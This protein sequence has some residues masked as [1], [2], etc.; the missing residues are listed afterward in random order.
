MAET[1]RLAFYFDLASPEC[2]L[3]AERV[4]HTLPG[5]IDWRPVRIA[6]EPGSADARSRALLERGAS[7]LGLLPLRWPADYPFDSEAAMIVATYA[8]SIGRGVAYAQAAFRQAFAGGHSLA[9]TDYVLLAGAAC[10]MHPNAMKRALTQRV[11]RE[12]LAR[13]TEDARRAGV[14]QLPA[15][16]AD[17]A[18]FEGERALS[19]AAEHLCGPPARTRGREHSPRLP[20]ALAP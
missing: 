19:E 2:Y 10:E 20:V 5:R 12:Q 3:A 15:V 13:E 9:E 18:L 7:E 8:R 6:R 4:L 16:S 1:S 11:V 17:A 14:T